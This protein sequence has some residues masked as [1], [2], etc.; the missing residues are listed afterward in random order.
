MNSGKLKIFICPT[1][2][3]TTYF[4]LNPIS[5]EY[6]G[7]AS[8]SLE[9]HSVSHQS[10]LQSHMSESREGR[11]LQSSSP[12]ELSRVKSD[13]SKRTSGADVAHGNGSHAPSS[14]LRIRSHAK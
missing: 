7:Y 14:G 5:H 2:Y 8:V 13:I 10:P 6:N 4:P 3:K 11:P 1:L 9:S 12:K